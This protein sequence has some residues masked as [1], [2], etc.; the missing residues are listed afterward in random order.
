MNANRMQKPMPKAA[1]S[2]GFCKCAIHAANGERA[3]SH[4]HHWRGLRDGVIDEHRA[5]EI[6]RRKE[7]EIRGK[8]EVVSDRGRHQAAN[9]IARDI[10]GDVGGKGATGVGG[11]ALLAQISEREREGGCHTKA[12]QNPEHSE[13]GQ[14]RYNREQRGRDRED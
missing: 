7:V 9:E 3:G 14:I 4:L 13:C 12:L 8:A 1:R 6:E 11:A 2:C 5:R 10:A